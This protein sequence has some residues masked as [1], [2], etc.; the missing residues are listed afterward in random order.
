MRPMPGGGP[1]PKRSAKAL[2]GPICGADRLG[3]GLPHGIGR[4]ASGSLRAGSRVFC[5]PHAVDLIAVSIARR[6]LAFVV[7]A[8]PLA[9][10]GPSARKAS[11]TEH[12]LIS[13]S[14]QAFVCHSMMPLT[15]S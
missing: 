4:M 6:S 13:D 14:H 9:R 11:P 8:T 7:P 15:K 3:T 1:V 2:V 12:W 5:H 10:R